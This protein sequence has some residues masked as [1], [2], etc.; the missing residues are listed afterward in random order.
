MVMSHFQFLY[1]ER[2]GSSSDH[3]FSGAMLVSGRVN[4]LKLSSDKIDPS[5]I[6][7][8]STADPVARRSISWA[9]QECTLQKL[10]KSSSSGSSIGQSF[11]KMMYLKKSGRKTP[12][13]E[14]LPQTNG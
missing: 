6:R 7:L 4:T 14:D 13:P 1:P 5:L 11:D 2:Q 12:G 3:Q 8:V 9:L 10:L